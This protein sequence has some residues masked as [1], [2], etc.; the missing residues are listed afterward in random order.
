MKCEVVRDLLP[1]YDEKLCSAESAAL[2]EE[3][4]KNC[5]ACK[6]LIEKLPRTELPKADTNAL[7]PFVKVKRRLRARIVGLIALGA[8]LLAVLIP[9]G[10]LTVNQIF[11]IKGGT[12]FEDLI[13]KH[14]IRQF[15]GM[16][17]EGRMEEYA[18]RYRN[19]HIGDAPDGTAITYRSFYL[20]KLKT[21]YENVKKYDPRV[22]EIHSSYHKHPDNHITRYLS[23]KLEFTR[24]DGSAYEINIL[25]SN[26]EADYE[27]STGKFGIPDWNDPRFMILLPT[28]DTEKSY[29]EQYSVFSED[30]I[31]TDMREIYAFVNTLYLA[32]GGDLDIKMIEHFLNKTAADPFEEYVDAVGHMIADRFAVSD[33]KAVYDGYA[34]FMRSDNLLYTAVGNEEFDVER[35]MFYYPVMLTGYDGEHEAAIVSVKLY[36][37]EYGLHSPSAED[38][39]YITNG[40]DLEMKMA[41]IFG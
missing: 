7:K 14:E 10:Y 16:I 26:Y 35:N 25:L 37:D 11:H 1:L 18:Q 28:L 24:S 5:A 22:G 2:V 13:Y 41:K 29:Y 40:S 20:E 36:F 33:Y 8:V 21:A 9:V 27:N 30:D 31:P 15:A 19:L 6:E 4:I 39:K 38:I 23:F 32:D 3:H 17:T 12:D 34:D